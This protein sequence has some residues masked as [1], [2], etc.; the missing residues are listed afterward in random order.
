MKRVFISKF[1]KMHFSSTALDSAGRS[2]YV[3]E[4]SGLNDD[5]DDSFKTRSLPAWVRSKNRPLAHLEDLNTIY[6]KVIILIYLFLILLL[7][8]LLDIIQFIIYRKLF[9]QIL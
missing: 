6:E 4:P 9:F 3:T 7:F 2:P 8:I 5:I 1:K